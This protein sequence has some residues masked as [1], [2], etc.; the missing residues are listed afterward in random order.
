MDKFRKHNI[1]LFAFLFFVIL[2]PFK[3][4]VLS[5]CRTEV[6][7]TVLAVSTACKR[8]EPMRPQP[9]IVAAFFIVSPLGS[10]KPSP[11]GDRDAM[12]GHGGL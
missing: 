3:Y 5:I 11:L 4:T 7:G 12:L 1:R 6:V 8:G 2:L 9:E 10:A